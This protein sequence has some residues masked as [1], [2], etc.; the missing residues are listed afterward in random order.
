MMDLF[1]I[2]PPPPVNLATPKFIVSP[3]LD[4]DEP[5]GSATFLQFLM[6]LVRYVF[7]YGQPKLLTESIDPN[8]PVRHDLMNCQV[9][10]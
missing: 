6:H 2:K 10:A 3:L 9:N 5:I 7:R 1:R 8:L 4:Y